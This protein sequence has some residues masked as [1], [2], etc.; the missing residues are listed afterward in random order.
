MLHFLFQAVNP[1][2][3][4]VKNALGDTNAVVNGVDPEEIESLN[5]L[6]TTQVSIICFLEICAC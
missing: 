2:K 1:E 4:K 3:A 5:A 6:V